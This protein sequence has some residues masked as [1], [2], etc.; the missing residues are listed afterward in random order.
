MT[1]A[2]HTYQCPVPSQTQCYLK[3]PPRAGSYNTQLMVNHLSHTEEGL[4]AVTLTH[5]T[6]VTL[7]GR[8]FKLPV[9]FKKK[10]V[11]IEKKDR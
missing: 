2:A 6:N 4:A 1:E 8:A 10:H 5:N 11:L 7:L 3:H 9:I